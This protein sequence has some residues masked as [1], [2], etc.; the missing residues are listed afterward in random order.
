MQNERQKLVRGLAESAL[1][2]ARYTR[3]GSELEGLFV[4]CLAAEIEAALGVGPEV[5]LEAGYHL[6][7]TARRAHGAWVRG[8]M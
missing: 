5:A 2:V 1:D 7:E 3:E 4:G 8:E 6:A